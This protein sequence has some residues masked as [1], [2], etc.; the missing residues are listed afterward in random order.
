MK[1]PRPGGIALLSIGLG[2]SLVFA[3]GAGR[4]P[5]SPAQAARAFRLWWTDPVAA[6]T[7]PSAVVLFS[8]RLPRLCAAVLVGMALSASGAAYQS[9]FRN[10]MADPGLLGTSTGAA[11]G[12][13]VGILL[14]CPYG[15]VQFLSFFGGIAAMLCVL[16]LWA[17][18]REEG[19]GT[20]PLVLC[21]IVVH[22]TA[23]ALLSLAKYAAD[24]ESKL[25]ALNTWLMGSLTAIGPS[26]LARA[27]WF[28]P[29]ALLGLW[30]LRSSMD[31]LALGED[32]AL[33]VG[34]RPQLVRAAAVVFSTLLVSAAVSLC[35]ILVWVGVLVPHLARLALGPRFSVLLPGTLLAGAAF[36]LLA[37]TLCRTL[38]PLE[39]PLGIATALTGAPAFAALLRRSRRGWA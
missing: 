15:L 24:P 37:D 25:P 20:V 35:G 28:F 6:G 16:G 34:A 26:D 30:A 8:L 32:D 12:A 5:V 19:E 36:L 22:S 4:Y 13:A 27:A 9:V 7:D 31:A 10:P 18:V 1:I 23:S 29:P 2:L 21:G 38:F 39:V 11:C 14:G 3:L 17:L 33:S